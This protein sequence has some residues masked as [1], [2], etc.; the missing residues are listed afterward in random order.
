MKQTTIAL[1]AAL[2]LVLPACRPANSLEQL[3]PVE[4]YF[5]PS[6]GCTEAVVAEI[7]AARSSIL[8]QAYSFTSAPIARALTEAHGR[9]VDVEAVIDKSQRSEKYSELDFLANAG[10]PTRIDAQHAIAHNKIMVIDGQVVI[11]G[12]FNFTKSAEENNAENLLIL[13][14]PKLAQIYTANWQAHCS[15]SEPY[16][17]TEAYSETHRGPG[18]REANP[19]TR[20]GDS[21]RFVSSQNSELFH[22]PDCRA[23]AKISPKNLVRYATREDAIRAGKKPCHECEP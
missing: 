22:R 12:S 17:R 7:N 4:V 6:G 10:I 9:G 2:L 14:D 13:R 8:V 3:P 21:G 19:P 15:H 20:S 16:V 5:S 18:P 23:A 11:T 1:I